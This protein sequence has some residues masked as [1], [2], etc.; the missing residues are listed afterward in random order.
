[1][2]NFFKWDQLY[3]SRKY[4]LKNYLPI[5]NL[6]GKQFRKF[7]TQTLKH[8]TSKSVVWVWR[9]GGGCIISFPGP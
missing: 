2:E 8:A 6:V 9:W 5:L 3:V 4:T 1:M 7:S